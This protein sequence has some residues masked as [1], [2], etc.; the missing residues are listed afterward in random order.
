MLK[1][2]TSTILLA[3]T[4]LLAVPAFATDFAVAANTSAVSFRS[5]ALLE[6]I[7]G[8]ST[9]LAG[10]VTTD[11]ANPAST[12]ATISFPVTSLVTGVDMRDEHL[13]G[14]DWLNSAEFPE[15]TFAL[16][17]A[18]FP[19]GTTLAHGTAVA[20]TVNG[21]LTIRGTS[22][23]VSA[24]A[25]VT[26]YEVA[27]VQNTYGIDSNVLRVESTFDIALSAFG[28]AIP[29]VLQTKVADTQSITV[30]L[31]ALQQ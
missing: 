23:P 31:T 12:T 28:V 5:D 8:T 19:A 26:F 11:L 21:T 25:T 16:T 20:G 7:V 3:G 1:N 22:Q 6:T 24:P 18:E 27:N 13:H 4:T 15:I 30:R 29:E 2:I 9:A 17:G 14:A 10:T